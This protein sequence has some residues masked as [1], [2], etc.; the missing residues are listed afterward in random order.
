MR[1]A[2]KFDYNET[3]SVEIYDIGGAYGLVC[4]DY[5]ANEWEEVFPTLSLALLRAA[6]LVACG[7]V[8]FRGF[9]T[10][11]SEEFRKVGAEFLRGQVSL[12]EGGGK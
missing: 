11:D 2:I 9:F 4:G 6:A 7:E 8:G 5:V 10:S 1:H 3:V 12:P